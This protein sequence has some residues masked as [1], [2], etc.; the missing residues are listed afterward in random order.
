MAR[1]RTVHAV[2]VACTTGTTVEISLDDGAGAPSH[3]PR[4]FEAFGRVPGGQDVPEGSF[5]D[6]LVVTV[7]F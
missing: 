7:L 3:D 4:L 1:S 2:T 5:Q 6:T